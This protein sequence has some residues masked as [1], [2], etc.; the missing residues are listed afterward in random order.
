MSEPR[1]GRIR[2]T[3]K[4]TDVTVEL[5]VDGNGQVEV[6]TGLGFF[7][8]MLTALGTHAGFDLRLTCDGDL[9]VD[10]HHTVEDCALALGEALDQALGS[11]TAIERFADAVVPM[12][13]TL[14]RAAID[15]VRRPH[16]EVRLG[17]ERPMIGAVA[18][19]MLTHA[20]RSLAIA[21]R[22]TLHVDILRGENDHHRAEAAFKATARALQA[23]VRLRAGAA[24]VSTKGV[25]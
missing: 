12:D 22:F 13:E 7:D 20:L 14:A 6:R 8:H 25:M 2:R 3:T 18:T 23:A 19:E 11:R 21:G 16:A 10:D 5:T 4:E 17:F 15:L 1:T 24:P 9:H